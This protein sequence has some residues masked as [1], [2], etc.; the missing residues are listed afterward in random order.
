MSDVKIKIVGRVT[1]E[2][3]GIASVTESRFKRIMENSDDW[4]SPL[5]DNPILHVVKC[6]DKT[7]IELDVATVT[8]I[9]EN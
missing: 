3:E 9:E 6:I 7:I 5:T 4:N 1:Y 2:Y 8:R